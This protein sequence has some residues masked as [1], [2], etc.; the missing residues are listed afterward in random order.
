MKCKVVY[1]S[2]LLV[3]L[4]LSL[5]AQGILNRVMR[6]SLQKAENKVED[7][8]VEKASEAIAERIYR[9]MSDAFDQM[10]IDASRQDSAYQANYPDS[11]AIKYGDLANNW[12]ARMN[13]TADLPESYAFDYKIFVETTTDGEVQNS[14]LYLATDGSAFAMEQYEKKEKRICLIDG[15]KDIVVLYMEDDKGKKTAQAIPNMLG[16]SSALVQ[17]LPDTAMS[18]WTFRATG[19]TKTVAGYSCDE[20]E[21]SDGEYEST[22]Y[23]TDNL[24]VSWQNAFSGFIDRFAGTKNAGLQDLPKGFMLE[25]HTSRIDKP[26]D[27]SSWVTQKVEQESFELK[28]AD[29]EFGGLATAE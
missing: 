20:Y 24:N 22:F 4:S 19:K 28:N 18:T 29:Y 5:D 14:V 17:S 12:M 15:A 10:L 13:E 1:L 25:S 26:K 6:R 23:I 8:L 16:M 2:I 9:S 3:G 21:S 11:I 7:M 27:Q